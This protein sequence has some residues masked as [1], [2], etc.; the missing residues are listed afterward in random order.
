ME[1]FNPGRDRP[2]KI[3]KNIM[4]PKNI[5]VIMSD[6][7]A[8]AAFGAWGNKEVQTPNL[9]ALAG[10]SFNFPNTYCPAPI[11]GPSRFA[12]LTGRHVHR[13]GAYDNGS[14]VPYDS[15]TLGHLMTNA[16]YRSVLCGRMHIHGPEQLVGFEERPEVGW[17][18]PIH[19]GA[20]AMKPRGSFAEKSLESCKGEEY[21][22]YEIDENPIIN[23]DDYTIEKACRTAADAEQADPR[24]LFMVIGLY[25]P[26]PSVRARK[27]YQELLE[28]YDKMELTVNDFS[29]EQLTQEHP[30]LREYIYLG[31]AELPDREY[32]RRMLV[33]YYARISYTDMLIGRF[34][35]SLKAR[36]E[37]D[38]ALI[39]YCSDHG[40]NMGIKGSWG[41]V[42]FTDNSSRIPLIVKPPGKNSRTDRKHLAS[43]VDVFPSL[44]DVCGMNVEYEINGNSLLPLLNEDYIEPAGP[45]QGA[46]LSQFH[47]LY[48]SHSNFMLREGD[49]KY[50]RYNSMEPQLFNMADD[51]FE[52]RNLAK[53]DKYASQVE[54]FDKRLIEVL[55][56]DPEDIEVHIRD[57]QARRNFIAKAVGNSPIVAKRLKKRIKDFRD[58][59]DSAWWD[60][61]EYMSRY[62]TQFQKT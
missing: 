50:C 9:D 52:C 57:N 34:L 53:E 38:D 58:E 19:A 24:P 29:A 7:H 3:K 10:N 5:Y 22:H 56:E 62:E 43:L 51:P 44:A 28:M 40:E 4:K 18:N 26:H 21:D 15:P 46:V 37:Y 32:N 55:G 23:I 47:G 8:A 1:Q 16:G 12:F 45:P 61:G 17:I 54:A 11:C 14:S 48:T 25:G 42:T 60:G 35:D 13:C 36:G 41:K 39:I 31:K 6:Q 30:F 59:L 20:A 27:E 2:E 33:E 49:Y